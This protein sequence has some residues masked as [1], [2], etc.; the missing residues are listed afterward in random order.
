MPF[1]DVIEIDESLCDGCGECVISCAEGAL[2]I[3][4]GKAKLVSDVYCDGLGACLGHCPQGAITVVR[5]EAAPYDEAAVALHLRGLGEARPTI[6]AEGGSSCP[7][8]RPLSLPVVAPAHTSAPDGHTTASQLGHWPVQL[9]LVSPL[10]PAFHG[11]DVLLAAD[12]VAFAHP[13][14]H[15]R[16]LSGR[17]LAVAC[18]KLDSH[19]EIYVEKLTAMIDQSGIASLT[20]AVM[21]VPC[22]SGLIRLAQAAAGRAS[23]KLPIRAVVIGVGGAVLGERAL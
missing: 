17:S 12:C 21:E 16:L 11:A 10:A 20:V 9:H 19:Q 5:R 1:R 7:G 13:D 23:R 3:I 8:S 18:P 15:R 22:C 2:R 14:F 6:V 4:G